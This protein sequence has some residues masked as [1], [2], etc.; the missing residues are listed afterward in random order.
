MNALAKDILEV[1]RSRGALTKDEIV[2]AWDMSPNDYEIIKKELL[3]QPSVGP[4]PKGTGGFQLSLPKS[5]LP[6]PE[7]EEVEGIHGEPWEN[8]TVA[9]L[10]ELLQHK[11]LE[12]LLG[13]LVWTVRAARK[14]RTGEDRRGTKTELAHALLLKHGRIDLFCDKDVRKII[15]RKCGIQHPE[16]WHP[17]KRVSHVFVHRTGFPPE[18]AG[19]PAEDSPE[20]FE[21]LEGRVEIK[22]LQNFQIEVKEQVLATLNGRGG[23]AIVTLPTGAGKTRVAVESIRDWL[24]SWHEHSSPYQRPTVLWLAHSSELCEQAHTEFLQ[25]WTSSTNVCP[26]LL[27]RFWGSFTQ[28]LMTHRETLSD[29]AKQPTLLISTPQRIVNLMDANSEPHAE[30]Q[31]E[32]LASLM[33]STSLIVVDEAHRAAAPSYVRILEEFG[34]GTTSLRV[35]GLTATPFR[36][37]YLIDSEAGTRELAALFP[38]LIEASL[39]LGDSPRDVLQ[40]RGILARPRFEEIKTSTVLE[41]PRDLDPL[42]ISEEDIQRTDL[43]L[44]RRADRPQRRMTVFQHIVP[45]CQDP[46]NAVLYFGPS[47]SDAECMALLLRQERISA[48]VV[49][50][51]TRDV[52]RRRIVSEFK[53]GKLRVLCNCEVLTSGFDAPRVTHVVVARPTVSTVLY[54]QMIGRGLRGPVFGG[55]EECVIIDCEDNYR[56]ERPVLGY[57]AFRHMYA[58]RVDEG[59]RKAA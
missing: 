4:G 26:L 34:T 55:T 59:W 25:V 7:A 5:R 57:R 53:E 29:I 21:Y 47:I 49:S 41:A 27:F 48:A 37:E 58:P 24:T 22:P 13:T 6:S 50:G 23:R 32:V 31:R 16:R 54:E 20:D 28:N 9:R 1:L 17:G 42:R 30:I 33:L 35:L 46:K 39:T 56:S 14:L 44:S 51:E 3:K 12:D 18:L 43:A 10:V 8:A 11:E 15:S 40:D 36:Q 52:T 38:R 19:I 2:T 45:I